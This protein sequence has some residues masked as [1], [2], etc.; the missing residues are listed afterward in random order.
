MTGYH[1]VRPHTRSNGTRVRGHTQRNPSR[2]SAGA[3]AGG[4]LFLLLVLFLLLLAVPHGT[5][6]QQPTSHSVKIPHS[7]EK[8][9][10]HEKGHERQHR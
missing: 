9:W 1:Y 7:Q 10:T 3:G 5:A 6:V 4:I 2:P 8:S